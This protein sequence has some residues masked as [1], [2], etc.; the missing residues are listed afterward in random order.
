MQAAVCPRMTEF[1]LM[2]VK[3]GFGEF[4]CIISDMIQVKSGFKL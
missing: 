1:A 4:T 2:T 3:N